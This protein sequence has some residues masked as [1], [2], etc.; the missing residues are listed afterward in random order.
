M[1]IGCFWRREDGASGIIMAICFTLVMALC[2]L[3]VDMGSAYAQGSRVQN[4]ADAAAL[5]AVQLL[6]IAADN[7]AAIQQVEARVLDYVVKN[8][9]DGDYIEDVSLEDAVDGSYTAVRV[10]LCGDVAYGFG[11]ILGIN[12]T[13]VTKHAKARVEP[14]TGTSKVVPLGIPDTSYAAMQE[15]CGG[16]HVI[17][18]YG[19]GG[20]TGGFFGALDLDG[21]QGGGARDFATWLA[22]GYDGVLR[23]GD[24][25]PVESGN[26]AGPTT[27]GFL[28]R[29]SQCT[30]F[31]GQGGCNA[32]QFDPDCP[33]VVTMIVYTMVGSKSVR[34]EGFAPFVLEGTN[35]KGEIV[36]SWVTVSGGEACESEEDAQWYGLVRNTLA[37]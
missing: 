31:P 20:G 30:H 5:A 34:V 4:A 25:L 8:G 6:P 29:Y 2:G 27:Q 24:V 19:G 23:V 36:A 14:A 13:T 28:E 7:P 11:P 22:F 18:K 12:G 10:V 1:G 3:V 9:L 15:A 21:V 32:Q 33:R 16:Q 35:G 26:M 37:E 17:V